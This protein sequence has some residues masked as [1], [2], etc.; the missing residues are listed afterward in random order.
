MLI[1]I[2]NSVR[3]NGYVAGKKRR[4]VQFGKKNM[5]LLYQEKEA[6]GLENR[7]VYQEKKIN[8]EGEKEII[9]V[10]GEKYAE[11]HTAGIQLHLCNMGV[12]CTEWV[13][14]H[15]KGN[16]PYMR[17]SDLTSP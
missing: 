1:P 16:L 10:C 17:D 15:G 8:W 4:R 2:Y 7:E 11:I 12:Y 14:R 3:S 13:C 6:E 5:D 9:K